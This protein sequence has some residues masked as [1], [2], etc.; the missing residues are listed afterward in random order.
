M[1]AFKGAQEVERLVKRARGNSTKVNIW[2][3]TVRIFIVNIQALEWHC[4]CGCP[5]WGKQ[6]P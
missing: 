3:N 1:L 6:E 2:L 5:G 4:G